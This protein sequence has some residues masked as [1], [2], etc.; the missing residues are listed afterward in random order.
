MAHQQE[1][2]ENKSTGVLDLSKTGVGKSI[3]GLTFINTRDYANKPF[4]SLILCVKKARKQ[5]AREITSTKSGIS[6]IIDRKNKPDLNQVRLYQSIGVNVF[7]ISNKELINHEPSRQYIQD[8]MDIYKGAG[9]ILLDEA[10]MYR[11]VTKTYD[12]DGK[13]VY[14]TLS[15]RN[16][17]K[18]AHTFPFRYL[19]TATPFDK[20]VAEMW[21]SLH[22][23]YPEKYD[24]YYSFENKWTYTDWYSQKTLNRE[25]ALKNLFEE[26]QPFTYMFELGDVVDT[27]Y[28]I[29]ITYETVIAPLPVKKLAKI[30][31]YT[32]GEE[33]IVTIPERRNWDGT[34]FPAN[35]QEIYLSHHFALTSELRKLSSIHGL[36]KEWVYENF[37]NPTVEEP[38]LIMTKYVTTAEEIASYYGVPV[39]K[40][41][42]EFLDS[43]KYGRV[44][45][46]T[47]DSL[48]Q[49]V[50]LEHIK[51]IVLVDTDWSSITFRQIR[52]RILRLMSTSNVKM[53]VLVSDIEVDK[54]IQGI[55]NG[56]LSGVAVWEAIGNYLKETKE[57]N[58]RN[59]SKH[60]N[61]VDM[62]RGDGNVLVK[63][64]EE[65]NLVKFKE[66]LVKFFDDKKVRFVQM[67]T[68]Y[69]VQ[70]KFNF[71]YFQHV[72]SEVDVK[73]LDVCATLT[74]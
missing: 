53:T 58:T 70:P 64:R 46:G 37:P 74:I 44:I 52:G 56:K 9:A 67:D 15:V 12:V 13:R 3:S 36:K 65:E 41:G 63:Y 61:K 42:V 33:T 47:I 1:V 4:M 38:L 30:L 29:D 40:A 69:R 66:D 24:N 45:V 18:V 50:S 57:G 55:L 39:V 72:D 21:V 43:I 32:F 2:G 51:Q 11:N 5:F 73:E 23:L 60:I 62:K 31:N 6:F 59:Y 49:S 20:T 28:D 14:K 25:G 17:I 22:I 8:V 27:E 10:H 16:A 68:Y 71:I 34:I 7:L 48:K 35:E 26:I 54:R 19:S